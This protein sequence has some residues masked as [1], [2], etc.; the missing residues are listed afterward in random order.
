MAVGKA[1][2]GM[3]ALIIP[4]ALEPLPEVGWIEPQGVADVVEAA[5]PGVLFGADPF[6]GVPEELLPAPARV[7]DVALEGDDGFLEHGQEQP[8]LGNHGCVR[9]K[10]A[11]HLDGQNRRGLELEAAA[12]RLAA[13]LRA[14]SMDEEVRIDARSGQTQ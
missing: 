11:K 13:R 7:A 12:R 6:L 14:A 3:G 1:K 8:L 2:P 9:R 4:P 10:P 5:A